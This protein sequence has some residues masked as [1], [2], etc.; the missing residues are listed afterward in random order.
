MREYQLYING[1]W[2]PAEAGETFE[3]TNPY[4]GEAVARVSRGRATDVDKA[5]K[6][7]RKAFDEGPWPRMSGE[8]RAAILNKAAELM[9]ER[10][11]ELVPLVVEESG[12]TVRKAKGECIVSTKQL[13]YFAKLATVDLTEALDELSKPGFSK[14]M[15]VREPIGVCAQ[16]VPWNFPVSMIIWKLGPALATGNTV[17]L[18]PA[19]ETPACALFLTQIFHDAGLP[20]GVLNVVTGYGPEAGEPLATHPR[21]DKVAFTGSTEIGKHIMQV[22]AGTMKRVSLECGGKSANIVLDDADLDIAVDGALY[23][24]YFHSGQCCT[25]G[26][27]LFLQ[28]G[29][30]DAFI[31]RFTD[32]VK[33]I[34]LGDPGSPAT[35]LGP[36]VSKQQYE[37]VMGYIEKGKAEGATCLLGGSGEASHN[38]VQPTVF[39]DVTN[40][41]A[42]AQEEIFGPVVSVIRFADEADAIRMANDSPYGLAGAVWSQDDAR[43]LR[44]AKQL[45]TGTVW[46]N[47]Y[48]MTSE[49]APFGGYKQSGLGRELGIEGLKAYTEIKHIH[50]DEIKKR[51]GK[52]WYDSVL[53]PKEP[54]KV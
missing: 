54:A 17:V 30:Y 16:I 42:I 23:A 43:A 41:M 32:K 24:I 22:A 26:S 12:S 44:V 48:H 7:A 38:L 20:P 25:A 15:L 2:I 53:A 21:V 28:E 27:R 31:Q 49:K 47:D 9:K 36:L 8:E 34:Q 6:A 29:I 50:L 37:R 33:A 4:T 46:I 52:P 35:D 3:S 5:V 40:E 1:Q 18:K 39:V 45:R 14:N 51:E 19:E 13:G 11:K 10:G